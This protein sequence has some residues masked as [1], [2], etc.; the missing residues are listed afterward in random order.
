MGSVLGVEFRKDAL[1][2]ALDGVLADGQ[3]IRDQLVSIAGRN[4][5]ENLDFARGQRVIGG[6]RRKLRGHFRMD[7]F[8]SGVDCTN[9]LQQ[10]LPDMVLQNIGFGPRFQSALRE[11]IATIGCQNDDSCVAEFAPDGED[12]IDPIHVRH[13]QVH[14]SDIRMVRTELRDG[15]LAGGGLRYQFHVRLVRQKCGNP[16]PQERMV[17]YSKDTNRIRSVAHHFLESCLSKTEVLSERTSRRRRWSQGSSVRFPYRLPIH[18]KRAIARLMLWPVHAYPG[19]PN[20][21]TG[22]LPRRLLDRCRFHRLAHARK[23][24]RHCR[25][26][27]LQFCGRESAETRFARPHGQSGKL[28]REGWDRAP[29]A[30]PRRA[31][32]KEP[33]Q[34]RCWNR[35]VLHPNWLVPEGCWCLGE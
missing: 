27:P 35:R 20:V 17:I 29:V 7:T 3:L 21:P 5:R 19:G 26:L 22:G 14:E 4:E 18:S 23:T 9:R 1:H 16:F 11:C 31:P 13:L 33:T 32:A 30:V 10:I 6:M 28:H 24:G 2:M 15:L 8:Y 25:L 12:G 34:G